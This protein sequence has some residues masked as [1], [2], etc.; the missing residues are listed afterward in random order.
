MG[1]ATGGMSGGQLGLGLLKGGMTGLSQGL[2][3]YG[4]ARPQQFDFSN[5]QQGFQANRPP[6][7]QG[8]TPNAKR[9]QGMNPFSQDPMWGGDPNVNGGFYT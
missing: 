7:G 1:Q 4:S 5:L 6:L 8:V 9:V 3:N 2:S